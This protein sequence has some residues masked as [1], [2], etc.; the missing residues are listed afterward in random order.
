VSEEIAP[1]NDAPIV[2]EEIQPQNG[3][4]VVV[5][6]ET[7]TEEQTQL[8]SDESSIVVDAPLTIDS[9]PIPETNHQESPA[10]EES[11][12]HP[13]I[14]EEIP[15]SSSFNSL[16]VTSTVEIPEPQE[17]LPSFPSIPGIVPSTLQ[18]S[19]LDDST[20]TTWI[21]SST[22]ITPSSSVPESPAFERPNQVSSPESPLN[23]QNP[24]YFERTPTIAHI[25]QKSGLSSKF[26][27]KQTQTHLLPDHHEDDEESDDDYDVDG[28]DDDDDGLLEFEDEDEGGDKDTED[29]N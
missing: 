12:S 13:P 8:N 17:P 3:V 23:P 28:E 21:S 18:S 5:E 10:T 24:Y 11:F 15:P 27:K 4:P 6:E 14:C 7:Q 16:S 29:D 1:H 19:E 2:E 20:A 9:M 26:M 22:D 25:P